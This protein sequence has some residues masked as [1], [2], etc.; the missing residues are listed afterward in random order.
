M[1]HGTTSYQRFLANLVV[2]E[3]GGGSKPYLGNKAVQWDKIDVSSVQFV[4]MTRS[5]L[6]RFRLQHGDLLVCEGGEVGRAAIW[7]SSL[8]ECYYQK[9]LH[10]LRPVCGFQPRLMLAF[11]QQW[12][13]RDLLSEYVSQTSIAHLTQ[14]KLSSIPLPTPAPNEQKA[15]VDHIG[16]HDAKVSLEVQQ[17]EKLRATKSGLMDDLLTGRVR[18]TDLLA[19]HPG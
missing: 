7:E 14:E 17:L 15:I 11:L 13:S 16:G 2:R 19:A 12:T 3:T 5:D 18:V 10:R 6:E 8:G 1:G 4:R 9:A